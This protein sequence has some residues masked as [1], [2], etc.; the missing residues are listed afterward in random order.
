MFKFNYT[1]K[2]GFENKEILELWQAI[3][4]VTSS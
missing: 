3:F 2:K 4:I 1:S